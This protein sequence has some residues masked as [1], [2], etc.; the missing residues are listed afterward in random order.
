MPIVRFVKEKKEIEVREGENL[1]T[2]AIRAGVNLYSS[3]T[4]F[5]ASVRKN[6]LNCHGWGQCGFCRVLIIKGQNRVSPMGIREKARFRC[7]VPTP[8]TPLAFD[9]LPCLAYIGN[10]D[11]MRLACCTT[12]HGDIDVE[13]N[14]ALNLFGENFFS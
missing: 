14:P 3:G 8:I 13:T 12:V 7:P 2:A 6:V 10:E 5:F 4:G 1:R 11:Q 9:P